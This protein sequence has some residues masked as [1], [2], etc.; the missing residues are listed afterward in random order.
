MGFL[1]DNEQKNKQAGNIEPAN[2]IQNKSLVLNSIL[3]L[4]A[5]I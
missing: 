3:L 4:K 5:H 1:K 2:N